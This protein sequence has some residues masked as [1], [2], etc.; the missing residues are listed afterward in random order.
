MQYP[1]GLEKQAKA[2]VN[3][4]PGAVAVRT[5]AV[6]GVTLVLGSDGKTVTPVPAAGSSAS[7]PAAGSGSSE[8]GSTAS[9]PAA[10]KSASSEPKPSSTD[11]KSYGKEGVCIN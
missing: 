6:T 2:V 5:S 8:A 11:V 10:T 7:S 3:V 1:A 4:V 9:K